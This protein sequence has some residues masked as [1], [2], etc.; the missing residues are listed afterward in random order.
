MRSERMR[1]SEVD[2]ESL[3]TTVL[4]ISEDSS[5]DA[6]DDALAE[7]FGVSFDQFRAVAEA[8]LPYTVP[9]RAAVTDECFHGFVA[10]GMFIVKVPAGKPGRGER[11][12]RSR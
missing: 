2:A 12:R 10:D 8:L 7:G 5:V 3:V 11:V 9:A 1:M 6:L 4:G